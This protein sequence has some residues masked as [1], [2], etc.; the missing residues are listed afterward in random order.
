MLINIFF[1]NNSKNSKAVNVHNGGQNVKAMN[2]LLK[3]LLICR[4]YI[5]VLS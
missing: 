4:E 5:K 1:I 3:L 2:V